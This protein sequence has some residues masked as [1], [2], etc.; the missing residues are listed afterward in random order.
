MSGKLRFLAAPLFAA[1][2]TAPALA[3]T[4]EV[5]DSTA[6][7]GV[8]SLADRVSVLEGSQTISKLSCLTGQIAKF[9]GVAWACAADDDTSAATVCGAGQVL[10]G[11]GSCVSLPSSSGESQFVFAGTTTISTTGGLGTR[12]F[13]AFCNSE[14]PGSRVCTSQ[15]ILETRFTTSFDDAPKSPGAWLRPTFVAANV[16]AGNGSL[17]IIATDM[18]GV[19]GHSSNGLT[20]D[21]WSSNLATQTGLIVLPGNGRFMTGECDVLRAVACC[22]AAP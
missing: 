1:L 13:S 12:T 5:V 16:T 19:S 21:G 14:F 20:C 18:S 2:A 17:D 11:D 7:G 9:N 22:A 10:T 6:R 3:Q 15:E 4:T 8:N